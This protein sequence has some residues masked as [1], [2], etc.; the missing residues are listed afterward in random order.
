MS[1]YKEITLTEAQ[2][3]YTLGIQFE[4]TYYAPNGWVE[5]LPYQHGPLDQTEAV[6]RTQVDV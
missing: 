5:W 6:Y 3:L 1:T 4:F 2:E